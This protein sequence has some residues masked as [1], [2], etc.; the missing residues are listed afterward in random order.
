[1]GD[2]HDREFSCGLRGAFRGGVK[3]LAPAAYKGHLQLF[4]F[5]WVRRGRRGS[6]LDRAKKVGGWAT[7]E[8]PS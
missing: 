4:S 3:S 2:S 5:S 1:V 7:Y 8:G 6:M